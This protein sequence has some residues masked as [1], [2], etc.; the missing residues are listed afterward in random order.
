MLFRSGMG[1]VG[2]LVLHPTAAF[3]DSLGQST[4]GVNNGSVALKLSYGEVDILFTGDIEGETDAALLAWGARLQAEVLKVAHHGSS[5]SSSARFLRAVRPDWAVISVGQFNRFGHPSSAVVTALQEN[6]ASVL[7][8]DR[9]GAVI[10]S[11]DGRSITVDT[12]IDWSRD[13]KSTRL[14]SSH[15]QQSRMPSSA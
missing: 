4:R 11:S 8:T 9:S 3:V 5:T 10:L 12:A 15:S 13:R 7:R 14:N 6:G 1:A 2:G